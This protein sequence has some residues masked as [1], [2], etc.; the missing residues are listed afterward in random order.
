MLD[1]EPR[2]VTATFSAT[3]CLLVV[4]HRQH[5]FNLTEGH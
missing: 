5:G 1:V 4:S 3:E 2:P